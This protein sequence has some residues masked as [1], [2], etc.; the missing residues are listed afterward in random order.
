[1]KSIYDKMESLNANK[2]TEN[3]DLQYST[4]ADNNLDLFGT[5]GAMRNMDEH[6]ILELFDSAYSEN[7]TVALANLLYLRDIL[8]GL[9]E[10][11]SFRTILKVAKTNDEFAKDL[12]NLFPY[13]LELGRWDDLLFIME[14][15][16]VARED[17]VRYIK[18]QLKSDLE[19]ETPSLCAK[20]M[21]SENASN[22]QT[23]NNAKKLRKLL[24]MSSKE[25][26]KTLS[27]IRKKINLIENQLRKNDYDSINYE[28]VPSKAMNKYFKAFFRNDED[29]FKKYLDDVNT[30]NKKINVGTLYPHE[31]IG[32]YY[33]SSYYYYFNTP[34]QDVCNMVI[35][36][37]DNIERI[38][39]DKKS[40]VVRDGS[41]SMYGTPLN[42]ATALSILLSEQLD[43]G[44][45]DSFITFSSKPQIVRFKDGSNIIEKLDTASKYDEVADTNIEAVYDL[46]FKTLKDEPE[47][48]IDNIIII[49]D[50]QFNC[51]A[52][53][54]PTYQ[55]LKDKFNKI[56]R[57]VPH[58]VYWN[59]N[60][61]D[62]GF[63]VSKYENV[64]LVSGFSNS[65]LQ[66]VIHSDI[67]TP[68][69]F[70]LDTLSYHIDI[71]KKCLTN[72]Q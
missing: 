71:V 34:D 22:K 66:S 61:T 12:K 55:S 9:G 25:Y 16:K 59:V 57:K 68:K 53:N 64:K 37:W 24:G 19:S 46:I 29:N 6:D 60:A 3:G 4:T 5:M 70:M 50:M 2:Y 21:P 26:R 54:I 41:G 38:S 18:N 65:L 63:P 10:R 32:K 30:G 39:S 36:Q 47:T 42:V 8:K 33:K 14:N 17:I 13:I 52:Y 28:Q 44:F 7:K 11:K 23:I 43:G 56:G 62:V 69:D 51:G 58:I 27:S 31:I 1:M 15:S 49:S 20:W 67:M 48:S 45:K 35:Q 40:I 72:N